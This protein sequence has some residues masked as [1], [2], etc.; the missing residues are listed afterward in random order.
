MPKGSS[1]FKVVHQRYHLLTTDLSSETKKELNLS[2]FQAFFANVLHSAE[3]WAKFFFSFLYL[4]VH[5]H[6]E[7]HASPMHHMVSLSAFDFLVS[8]VHPF[9]FL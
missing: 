5:Q 9:I 6:A 7:K 3:K 4:L 1:R 8:H 2:A